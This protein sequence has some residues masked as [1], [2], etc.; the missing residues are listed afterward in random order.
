[1]NDILEKLLSLTHQRRAYL[2]LLSIQRMMDDS[3]RRN[4]LC[5]VSGPGVLWFLALTPSGGECPEDK[6]EMGV[7]LCTRDLANTVTLL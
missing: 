6:V 2:N 4:S 5:F 7:L 1:M 3:R